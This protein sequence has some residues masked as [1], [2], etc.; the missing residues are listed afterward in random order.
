MSDQS[1]LPTLPRAG[2]PEMPSGY[3][4]NRSSDEGLLPWSFVQER[5]ATA[6]NYWLATARPDGRPHVAP[7]W[8]LWLDE[9]FY[10]AT[11]PASRK[12]RNLLVNPALVVHLES[13]DD[14]VI[15]EGAAE[16]VADPSLRARFA[17]A[18]DAKYQIRPDVGD[19]ALVYGLRPRV[20]QAWREQDFPNSA[21]RWLLS[22][23]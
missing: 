11:D 20:A 14:V 3:G 2:R 18:Y 7:V 10:F 22:R 19:A 23:D 4:I 6:R 5:L 9:A 17:E 1:G 16:R 13:G 15:L 21:T 8:G 12:A